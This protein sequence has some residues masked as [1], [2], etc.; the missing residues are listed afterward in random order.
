MGTDTGTEEK[1]RGNPTK[2]SPRKPAGISKNV[3][4]STK[5]SFS[6][7]ASFEKGIKGDFGEGEIVAAMASQ[8]V[9]P[10]RKLLGK[11]GRVNGFRERADV[12]GKEVVERAVEGN[13]VR[14]DGER[15]RADFW[16]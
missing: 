6:S 14:A 1:V 5:S 2:G 4:P 9:T 15:D 12:D 16:P 11:K 8:P 13:F 3:S 7:S 10:K